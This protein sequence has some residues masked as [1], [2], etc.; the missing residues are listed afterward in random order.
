MAIYLCKTKPKN[1]IFFMQQQLFF[2][3]LVLTYIIQSE[4]NKDFLSETE[5][6]Q[7]KQKKIIKTSHSHV[8]LVCFC[9]ILTIVYTVYFNILGECMPKI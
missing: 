3:Y 6:T 2:F 7:T 5:S 8:V 4:I 9:L 1:F